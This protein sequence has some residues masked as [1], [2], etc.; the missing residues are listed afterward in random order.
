MVPSGGGVE[1]G[2]LCSPM[3]AASAAVFS[4]SDLPSLLLRC[5]A[6]AR[7]QKAAVRLAADHQ[8][9]TKDLFFFGASLALES[10]LELLLG[11]ATELVI[12]G[13]C[14]KSTVHLTSQ[15]DQ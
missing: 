15:S 6:S 8:T 7:I 5:N 1:N 14:I 12:T 13:C 3:L 9:V 4:A 2:P 10:T 11:P